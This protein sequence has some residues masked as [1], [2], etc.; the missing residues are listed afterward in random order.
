MVICSKSV[1]YLLVSLITISF[2]NAV[3]FSADLKIKDVFLKNDG[4]EFMVSFRM[5]E[6]FFTPLEEILN[7]GAKVNIIFY[8][9][10]MKKRK[11]WLDE[12]LLTIKI[13]H[14]IKYDL[15]KDEFFLK[16]SERKSGETAVK[17][18]SMAKKLICEVNNLKLISN[19]SIREG[20]EYYLMIKGGMNSIRL[21]FYL[22]HILFFLPGVWSA[23]TP[24]KIVE[25]KK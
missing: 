18:A 5:D 9:K 10:I 23:E 24:W 21:P 25:L 8:I 7:S 13:K 6:S 11:L 17:D 19:N 15:L 3:S 12:N 20:E 4:K 2:T 16:F 14:T 22:N 1:I